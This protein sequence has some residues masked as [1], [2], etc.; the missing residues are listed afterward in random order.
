MSGGPCLS[1]GAASLLVGTVSVGAVSVPVL[2]RPFT[3]GGMGFRC[4]RQ[5][6]EHLE[7]LTAHHK[8]L[9]I[10]AEHCPESFE[11]R[12]ALAAAKI[13]RIEGRVVDAEGL[14]EKAIRSA[15]R[16]ANRSGSYD[17]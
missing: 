6:A 7:G 1:G 8:Q 14:Y 16:A 9:E 5:E 2:Q 13:A 12:A 17:H 15:R 10:W 3:P 4:S 11:N